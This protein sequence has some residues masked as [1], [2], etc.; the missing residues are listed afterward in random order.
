MLR[1]GQWY[2]RCQSLG[3]LHEKK[4]FPEHEFTK[5]LY[6]VPDGLLRFWDCVAIGKD[7]PEGLN[8]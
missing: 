4:V 8:A 7:F 5:K 2:L 1:G 3:L 6:E